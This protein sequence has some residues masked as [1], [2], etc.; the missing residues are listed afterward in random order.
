MLLFKRKMCLV[1]DY[2]YVEFCILSLTL[3]LSYC[4]FGLLLSGVDV[5]MFTCEH[6][7]LAKYPD[8]CF[9]TSFCM[10]AIW[11]LIS[12]GKHRIRIF[13]L[14]GTQ[15]R[16]RLPLLC[17]WRRNQHVWVHRGLAGDWGH[18]GS[19]IC[20]NKVS[21]PVWQVGS[22]S[23]SRMGWTQSLLA[24]LPSPAAEVPLLTY[25]SLL[26]RGD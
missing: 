24:V 18:L 21:I 3:L 23:A 11:Q 8:L 6:Y 7:S 26:P 2:W 14:L 15:E 12:E 1:D 25:Q 22:S 4:G 19:I 5:F 10:S 17:V 9:I 13:V 20:L 16:F